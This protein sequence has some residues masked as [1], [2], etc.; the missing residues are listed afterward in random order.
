[1]APASFDQIHARRRAALEQAE[2][3]ALDHFSPYR[4]ANDVALRLTW[5]GTDTARV[6]LLIELNDGSRYRL[7]GFLRDHAERLARLGPTARVS[8]LRDLWLNYL[9][10]RCAG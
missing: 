2:N 3:P 6:E 4:L 5:S 10:W 1:M 9:A 7:P 8:P